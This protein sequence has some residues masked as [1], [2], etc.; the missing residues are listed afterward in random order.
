MV[1]SILV[2]TGTFTWVGYRNG[3]L[4]F[5]LRLTKFLY[6]VAVLVLWLVKR[7]SMCMLVPN[8]VNASKE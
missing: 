7:L 8:V 3:S 6:F 4:D 2:S 5:G 1:Q